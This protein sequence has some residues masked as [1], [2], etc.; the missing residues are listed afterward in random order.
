MLEDKY[1]LVAE[2]NSGQHTT[3]GGYYENGKPV[4]M[5]AIADA[6]HIASFSNAKQA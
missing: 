5:M 4:F 6:I 2:S 1:Y 3:N